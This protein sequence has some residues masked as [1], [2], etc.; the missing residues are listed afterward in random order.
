MIKNYYDDLIDKIL[1]L[2]DN[3][4]NDEAI[5]LIEEEFKLPYIPKEYENKLM[6]IYQ[7][8]KPLEQQKNKMFS[9][10]EIISIFLNFNN[11][12]SNDTLLEISQLMNEYNWNDYF[13]E[14]QQIFNKDNICNNVK[15][16]IY[17]ILSIQNVNYKFKI[18][19]Y[20]LIPTIDKT[21]YESEFGIKN[22]QLLEK[23]Y[24]SEPNLIE[25]SKKILMFYVLNLFP[26]SL[27][28]EFEN[29]SDDL[30]E[31]SKCMLGQINEY[32]LTKKQKSIYE[33]IKDNNMIN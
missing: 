22:F 31:I 24:Y 20:F 9:K 3:K 33:I 28:L 8:I 23:N 6:K 10:D 26:K 7:N 12:H 5:G 30:I 4:K 16:M 27:F 18:N 29:I 11:E 19:N 32:K 1:D 25:I 14:I 17:N 21:T 2:I 13:E 15:A